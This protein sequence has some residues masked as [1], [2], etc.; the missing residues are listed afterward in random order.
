MGRVKRSSPRSANGLRAYR[1]ARQ[2]QDRSISRGLRRSKKVNVQSGVS[3]GTLVVLI[4][5]STGVG[6][7]STQLQ[8]DVPID[9]FVVS[10]D[11]S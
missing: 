4:D 8:R 2:E 9:T 5:T 10:I 3:I 7:R 11:T 1:V 6:C